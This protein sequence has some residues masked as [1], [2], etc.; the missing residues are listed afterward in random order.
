MYKYVRMHLNHIWHDHSNG[1]ARLNL[2]DVNQLAH[3]AGALQILAQ[4]PSCCKLCLLCFH[5]L[6]RVRSLK[7]AGQVE[8]ISWIFEFS[9]SNIVQLQLSSTNS[10]TQVS[11]NTL[12]TQARPFQSWFSRASESLCSHRHLLDLPTC[13]PGS[14]HPLEHPFVSTCPPGFLDLSRASRWKHPPG[15]GFGKSWALQLIGSSTWHGRW[16]K[17]PQRGR[18]PLPSSNLGTRLPAG[19]AQKGLTFVDW[20]PKIA[21]NSH[22]TRWF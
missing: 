16:H 2:I 5:V 13:P 1:I 12:P 19:M 11:V 20:S 17:N 9:L 10:Q 21:L 3:G 15:R 14:G 6:R 8:W 22:C 4:R 7:T 18:P